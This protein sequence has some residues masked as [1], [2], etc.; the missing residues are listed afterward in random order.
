M[1]LQAVE[2]LLV[3][4]SRRF[5][6][7]PVIYDPAGMWQMAQRLGPTA[8]FGRSNTHSRSARTVAARCCSCS[9]Y[10]S[11]GFILLTMLT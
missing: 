3:A 6:H 5:S 11:T 7:T 8:V 10:A 9:W 1:D 4:Q 2:E